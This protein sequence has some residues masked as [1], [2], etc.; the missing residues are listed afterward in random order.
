MRL[1][2]RRDRLREPGRVL[3]DVDQRDR[4]V[5]RRVQDGKAERA[6]QHH[7]A[8][9]RTAALPERDR[10]VQ[11]RDRQRQRDH[12]MGEA[13]LFQIAQASAPR[14]QFAVDGVVEAV[15]LV[16]EPAERPHQRHVV[17]DVDHFAVDGG[18]LVGVVVM[19]R[20]A[21]GRDPEHGDEDDACDHDHAGGHRQADGSN[22]RDRHNCGDARRQH[23]PYEHVLHRENGVRGGR[24]PA[25][26]HARQPI[27]EI[28]RGVAGQ[29][30]EHVAA[31]IAGDADKREARRPARDAPQQDVGTDQRY[32][33]NECQPYTAAMRR[34]GGERVDEIFDAI[35]GA[36]RA[37]NGCHNRDQ[38]HQMRRAP[39]PQIAH[40]KVERAVCVSRKIVHVPA[41]TC[42]RLTGIPSGHDRGRCRDRHRKA[43]QRLNCTTISQQSL[44]K[45]S[46]HV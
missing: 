39:L 4:K 20:L 3:G 22:Q 36:D 31:Q 37:G 45:K 43:Q 9:R 28:T 18:G 8:G 40:H 38:N 6:D 32:E 13:K 34:P 26:Q 23:V 24:D 19:Q 25:C 14:G 44:F 12:G 29:M 2:Q 16:V 10:P 17:D 1:Q 42:W 27:D 7:V 33:K 30:A 46:D 41:K 15:V 35:L 21:R 11:Q 5:A